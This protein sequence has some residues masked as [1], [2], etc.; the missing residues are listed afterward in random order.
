MRTKTWR[1]FRIPKRSLRVSSAG[2]LSVCVVQDREEDPVE[3]QGR[4]KEQKG[5]VSGAVFVYPQGSRLWENLR[6]RLYYRATVVRKE[7]Q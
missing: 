6:A 5:A 2:D 1:I 7:D 3:A 4:A